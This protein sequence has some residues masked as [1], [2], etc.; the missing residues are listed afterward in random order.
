MTQDDCASFGAV[1][2]NSAGI[3]DGMMTS[4]PAL[5]VSK[6]KAGFGV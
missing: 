6:L 3:T 2:W 4:I 5:P 1:V